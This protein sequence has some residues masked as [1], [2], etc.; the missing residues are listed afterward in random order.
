MSLRNELK[1]MDQ[2]RSRILIKVDEWKMAY[3]AELDA[4]EVWE[5]YYNDECAEIGQ[6][7]SELQEQQK[8]LE[9]SS[10]HSTGNAQ[11]VQ[12][13]GSFRSELDSARR[14]IDVLKAGS[15]SKVKQIEKLRNQVVNMNFK[16]GEL[17][18]ELH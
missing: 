1:E 13:L 17:Q 10:S 11:M 8:V 16:N 18:M 12:A 2:D 9:S 3:D 15:S 7:A 4:A 6:L 5:Q 14:E